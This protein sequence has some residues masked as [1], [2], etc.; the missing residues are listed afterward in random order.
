MQ[1]VAVMQEEH[2]DRHLN[3]GSWPPRRPEPDYRR[4]AGRRHHHGA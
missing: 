4:Q 1:V 2:E 3:L